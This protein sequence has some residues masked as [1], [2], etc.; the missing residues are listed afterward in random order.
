MEF[1]GGGLFVQIEGAIGWLT[2]N[3]PAR[4]NAMRLDMWQALP[5]AMGFLERDPIVRC[6]IVRGAG[7]RAFVSGADIAEFDEVRF[8]AASN[9]AFVRTVSAASASIVETP[10]PV[11]AMIR[12]YCIGGGMVIASAC[13]LRFCSAG[14]RFGVPAAKLGIGYE[15]DN[16]RRL[17]D[18]VGPGRALEMLLTARQFGD[19]EAFAAG[20]V[21]GVVSPDE[22]EQRVRDCAAM[23]AGNAPR[24][25]AAAKLANRAGLDRRLDADAQAAIDACFDSADFAEGRTAFRE[26]RRA[27]FKGV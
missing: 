2:I 26:K 13:D 22:L 12:G 10:K 4:L 14:S 7:E 9:D 23:M 5:A 8:D 21:N 1:A 6:I 20:F 27:I 19:A 24:S 3:Q 15:L 18:L 17:L 11:I 16:Y 25:L